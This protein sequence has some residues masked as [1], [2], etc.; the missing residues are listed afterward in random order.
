MI[1][2]FTGAPGDGKTSTT[3]W[4]LL[5]NIHKYKVVITNIRGFNVDLIKKATGWTGE[6]IEINNDSF[7]MPDSL[8]P[9]L[10]EKEK[11]TKDLDKKIKSVVKDTIEHIKKYE[12]ENIQDKDIAIDYDKFFEEKINE[13]YK[14]ENENI[15]KKAK[16]EVVK[17]FEYIARIN[18]PELVP[19]QL[20]QPTIV[21]L[22][23]VHKLL[24]AFSSR[25]VYDVFKSD[26]LSEHRHFR[27]DVILITQNVSKI[28]SMYKG[29]VAFWYKS[30]QA[31]MKAK[32][33]TFKFEKFGNDT[34]THIPNQAIVFDSLKKLKMPDGNEYSI[35]DFY[36]SG[37]GGNKRV[38]VKSRIMEL[39]IKI[40]FAMFFFLVMAYIVYGRIMEKTKS[41]SQSNNE[42]QKQSITS[43]K[44]IQD[45]NSTQKKEIIIND[46]SKYIFKEIM[47]DGKYYYFD[48]LYFSE[49]EFESF[50]KDEKIIIFQKHLI[51]RSVYLVYIYVR[52]DFMTIFNSLT[53][54]KEKK[55][56][57]S[58]L[59]H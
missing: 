12:D 3:L 33:T 39:Y 7:V 24:R 41:A 28:A 30:I 43:K 9:N 31:E 50:I 16:D 19:E 51:A 36:I 46:Y 14:K 5:Q 15:R 49:D 56:G 26:F 37:D 6:F 17:L 42:I 55:K 52:K 11:F 23:E 35:F 53:D 2:G 1:F 8:D 38:K 25:D 21:I 59:G 22:D 58:L 4:W 10:K 27:C 54:N 34:T 18:N 57:N 47:F 40:A 13:I 29:D 48:D 44:L 32:M 45:T 20:A